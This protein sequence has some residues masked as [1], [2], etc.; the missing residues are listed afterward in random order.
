MTSRQQL[1]KVALIINIESR[2]S[3]KFLFTVFN[4]FI[5]AGVKVATL[6]PV[7]GSLEID[8]AVRQVIKSSH[9]LVVIGGGDGTISSVIGHFVNKK[10][11]LGIIPLGTANSFIQSLEIPSDPRLAVKTILDGKVAKI[12]IGKINNRYF[13]NVISFG[14]TTQVAKNLS[15]LSKKYFGQLSYLVEG[16]KQVR[17][18]EPLKVS[19]TH[20]GKR[21]NFTTYQVIIANGSFYGPSLLAKSATVNNGR[22]VV[23]TMKKMGRLSL[24]WSWLRSL[25]GMDLVAGGVDHF[26][27]KEL[28]VVTSPIQQISIDGE[29]N[30]Q[31]P[32]QLK[33]IPHAVSVIVPKTF[34][35]P[36]RIVN[37]K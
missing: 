24:A 2:K 19:L 35:S 29:T 13:A 11:A 36:K 37:N 4:E 7:R 17:A 33:I 31:T 5:R 25:F 6:L 30:S 27:A 28:S 22:L 9:T 14:F 16:L 18:A 1:N 32:L 20:D 3:E 8:Q 10:V 26:S 23:L 21:E 34:N 12:D 15:T